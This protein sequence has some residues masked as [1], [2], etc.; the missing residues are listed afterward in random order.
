M[1]NRLAGDIDLWPTRHFVDVDASFIG[2]IELTRHAYLD[3]DLPWAVADPDGRHVRFAL[4]NA[5]VGAHYATRMGE[6]AAFHL[7][8]TLS[9]QTHW[10]RGD[11]VGDYGVADTAAAARAL[12]DLHR[13]YP[14]YTFIRA[15]LGFEL[16]FRPIFLRFD[17]DGVFWIPWPGHDVDTA[18]FVLEEATEFEALADSGFGGGARLQA[19]FFPTGDNQRG[20]VG[21]DWAQLGVEGFFSYEPEPRGFFMRIGALFGVD[22]P[23]GPPGDRNNLGGN[24]VTIRATLGGKW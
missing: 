15:P 3:L 8:G 2:Q 9:F 20:L 11:D 19:V 6:H 17:F 21:R 5:T 24:F 7:G 10:G 1:G 18:E 12:Y 16:G 14:E 4:G 22:P 23:F 13:F